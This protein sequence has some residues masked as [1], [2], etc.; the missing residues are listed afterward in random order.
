MGFPETPFTFCLKRYFKKAIFCNWLT[1]KTPNLSM[2]KFRPKCH[3]VTYMNISIKEL[4]EKTGEL[5]RQAAQA[6]NP[7]QV[8]DRGRVV[9]VIASPALARKRIKRGLPKD[10]LAFIKSLPRTDVMQYLDEER[11]R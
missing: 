5:V 9:A 11:E 10:F 2:Y 7:V 8:T 3:S 4:H 6:K 1:R